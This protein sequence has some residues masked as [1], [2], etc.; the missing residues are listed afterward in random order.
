M[1]GYNGFILQ[2]DQKNSKESLA[3]VY[4][5]SYHKI[6]IKVIS[7]YKEYVNNWIPLGSIEFI[8]QILGRNIPPNHYPEFLKDYFNRRIWKS[9][10]WP[11]GE[12]VFIKPADK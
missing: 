7:N 2:R 10:K 11:L 1:L 6:P 8:S 5:A 3:I 12:K 4:T 9:D